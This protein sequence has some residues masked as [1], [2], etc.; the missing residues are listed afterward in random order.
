[1]DTESKL[2]AEQK[3][4]ISFGNEDK[5]VPLYSLRESYSHFTGTELVKEF[6]LS[7]KTIPACRSP[8]AIH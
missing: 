8:R 6:A 1:M 2:R 7:G 3:L 4:M 5:S